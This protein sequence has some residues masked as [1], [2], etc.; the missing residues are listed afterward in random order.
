MTGTAI[1][2]KGPGKALFSFKYSLLAEKMVSACQI[3]DSASVVLLLGSACSKQATVP[4]VSYSPLYL[5]ECSAGPSVTLRD[6]V[7][8]AG[9]G[10]P[11]RSVYQSICISVDQ[12]KLL[13][14]VPGHTSPVKGERMGERQDKNSCL[15]LWY[16]YF[17][18]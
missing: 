17:V 9:Q 4:E 8:D 16:M 7:G 3:W 2:N 15:G 6:W 14:Y 13:L 12:V 18:G 10:C 11:G 1:G 5:S